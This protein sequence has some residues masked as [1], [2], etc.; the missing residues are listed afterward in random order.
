M[1]R[2]AFWW[3]RTTSPMIC[4]L[5][6]LRNSSTFFFIVHICVTSSAHQVFSL[7]VFSFLFLSFR[8]LLFLA[9][10]SVS[11]VKSLGASLTFSIQYHFILAFLTGEYSKVGQCEYAYSFWLYHICIISPVLKFSVVPKQIWLWTSEE[12]AVNLCPKVTFNWHMNLLNFC[13]SLMSSMHI[14]K[15]YIGSIFTV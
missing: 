1:H 8:Y 11:S 9:W 14:W 5:C 10:T 15:M 7:T 2:C 3:E 4:L 12:D 13:Q 6:K